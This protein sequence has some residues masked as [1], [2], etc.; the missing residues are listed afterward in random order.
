MMKYLISIVIRCLKFKKC[1]YA[2]TNRMKSFLQLSSI[3]GLK[4]KSLH[5]CITKNHTCIHVHVFYLNNLL[6]HGKSR[7]SNANVCLSLLPLSV[8]IYLNLSLSLYIYTYPII[9]KKRM[10]ES[11]LFKIVR[12]THMVYYIRDNP[13]AVGKYLTQCALNPH[14]TS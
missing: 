10:I 11:G 3:P 12:Q 5:Y 4:W 7:L 14:W 8:C 13:M 1:L 9:A 2:K 6:L